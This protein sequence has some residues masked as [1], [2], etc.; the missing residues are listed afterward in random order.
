MFQGQKIKL[1]WFFFERFC[2]YYTS[3]TFLS[4]LTWRL[5]H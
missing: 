4:H 5:K 3:C 1:C 2:W